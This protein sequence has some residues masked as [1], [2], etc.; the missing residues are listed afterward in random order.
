MAHTVVDLLGLECGG[1]KKRK[2]EGEKGKRKTSCD[3]SAPN[4][5]ADW[6]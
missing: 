1:E 3:D 4:P 2:A 5:R 6:E